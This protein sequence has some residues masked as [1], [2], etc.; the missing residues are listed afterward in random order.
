MKAGQQAGQGQT[1]KVAAAQVGVSSRTA[2]QRLD[3]WSKHI[4]VLAKAGQ[5]KSIW[6]RQRGSARASNKQQLDL[7]HSQC[8]AL[9]IRQHQ[10]QVDALN[11]WR[12]AELSTHATCAMPRDE[13]RDVA[14][15]SARFR[16]DAG[17]RLSS[18]GDGRSARVLAVE[19]RALASGRVCVCVCV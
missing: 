5:S 4:V 8:V 11:L 3:H 13:E 2:G 17:T 19:V 7:R 9:S 10:H 18:S 12:P 6:K 1:S 14:V 16:P 15:L